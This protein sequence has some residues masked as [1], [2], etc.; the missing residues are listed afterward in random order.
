M[1][2]EANKIVGAVLMSGVIA[3]TAGYAARLTVGGGDHHGHHGKHAKVS[4][5]VPEIADDHGGEEKGSEDTLEDISP[6]LSTVTVER[7]EKV[8][9]K[10]ASCHVSEDGS[11]A[12]KTGPNLWGIVGAEIAAVDGYNYGGLSDY[13]DRGG[14]TVENLN[15]FLAA[16]KKWAPGTKMGFAGLKKPE[17]RAAIVKYLNQNSGAPLSLW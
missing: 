5:P 8:F 13:T 2:L 1:S 3:M 14:W 12:K 10:C 15:G 7:G 16:P 9:K 4:Y 11:T 17:D 6:L